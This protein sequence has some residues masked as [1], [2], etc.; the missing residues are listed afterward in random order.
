MNRYEREVIFLSKKNTEMSSQLKDLLKER[1][2][3]DESV[4]DIKKE[5]GEKTR[6]CEE[7]KERLNLTEK[8]AK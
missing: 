8:S 6:L 2:G 5:L 1:A 7:L 3:F 4:K